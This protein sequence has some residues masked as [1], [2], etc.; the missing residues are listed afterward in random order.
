MNLKLIFFTF[1]TVFLFGCFGLFD[2]DSKTITGKYIVVWIDLPENQIISERYE[3]NSAGS[4]QLV[5]EYV[6]SVGHNKE[7]IIAK[8][9][10][11]NGFEGGYKVNTAITNYYIIDMNRKILK[12][13][14]KVF[15]PLTLSQFDSLRITLKI[16]EIPFD[17]N[18]PD[19]P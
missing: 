1:F 17:I 7:F 4:S 3:I 15:G 12:N 16:E 8:Q 14:Q 6:F 11:T 13:G 18:Y 5:P 10:P 9:H 2:S 19:K